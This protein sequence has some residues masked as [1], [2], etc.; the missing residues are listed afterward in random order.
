MSCDCGKRQSHNIKYLQAQLEEAKRALKLIIPYAERY[1]P[2]E[3]GGEELIQDVD[4]KFARDIVEE[5]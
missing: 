1:D 2:A 3:Y 4:I 5:N